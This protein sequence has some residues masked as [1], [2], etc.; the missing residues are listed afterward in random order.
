[1]HAAMTEET[2][3]PEAQLAP[4]L[5]LRVQRVERACEGVVTLTLTDPGG[6]PLPP[7]EPGAHVDLVLPSSLVRQYSLCGDPEDRHSYT[8]AVLRVAEGRGG[9]AEIH[10]IGLVGRQLAVRGPR[11]R[12]GLV[13]AQSYL[14]LA[15]GI[16]IT[17]LKA[18][19]VE[20]SGRDVPWSLVY[21]ARS[22][23]AMAFASELSALPGGSVQF[24]AEDERGRPD[25]A[26]LIEAAPSGTAVYC[27]GPEPMLTHV[28]ALCAP[29][30]GEISF[31][32]ERFGASGAITPSQGDDDER[33]FEIEL[34]RRNMV[35][36]V[37]PDRTALEVVREVVRN[38]PY[39]CL[40]GECGSCEVTV[41]DG[42]VD[43]RDAVL[44]DEERESNSVMMLCVSRARSNRLVIDL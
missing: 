19:A 25:F 39:S 3:D 43:H 6:A 14:L 9:S 37:P 35:L 44:S 16:G 13:P 17:P 11:N 24:V 21:G 32:F 5:F 33:P 10:D 23:S 15:G 30:L 34:K 29:R 1:M 26:G 22:R 12:F 42:L 4:S 18:M 41:I 8:V 7:W 20:L 38:H 40:E 27:C 28:E 2:Y 36:Q 31:H